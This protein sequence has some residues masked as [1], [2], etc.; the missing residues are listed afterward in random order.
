L[1][2]RRYSALRRCSYCGRL[3]QQ[4]ATGNNCK[5]THREK[6]QC[7]WLHICLV[8]TETNEFDGNVDTRYPQSAIGSCHIYGWFWFLASSLLCGSLGTAA[9]L[10]FCGGL[11]SLPPFAHSMP[12][13]AFGAAGISWPLSATSGAVRMRFEAS[14]GLVGALEQPIPTATPTANDHSLK[15]LH[16][17]SPRA[18]GQFR[19]GSR[20]TQ[21]LSNRLHPQ[22]RSSQRA[23]AVLCIT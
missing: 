15:A 13:D 9:F 23:I 6:S 2:L 3:R 8:A 21:A 5:G 20:P 7:G 22:R 11:F 10:A 14:S 16:G 4:R 19:I 1:L 12:G 18:L 17:V